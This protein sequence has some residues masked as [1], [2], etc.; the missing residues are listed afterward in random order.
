VLIQ[1]YIIRDIT[2]NM[3]KE[4]E[5]VANMTRNMVKPKNIMLTL[6]YRRKNNLTV[7]TQI[8]NA[9]HIYKTTIKGLRTKMQQLLKC[10][11]G[12][13]YVTKI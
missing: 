12:N 7:A 2:K 4:A 6:K 11:E 1:D 5:L 13:K 9:L 3:V 10:L 8:Y